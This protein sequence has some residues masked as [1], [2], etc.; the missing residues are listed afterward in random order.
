MRPMR[1]KQQV[2]MPRACFATKADITE[3]DT[4]ADAKTIEQA[5]WP[6]HLDS[7]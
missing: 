1:R 7:D 4:K 6:G 5:G 3:N 2:G